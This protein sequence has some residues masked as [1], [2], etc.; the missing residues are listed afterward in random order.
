LTSTSTEAYVSALNA[1]FS[2]IL[3]DLVQDL[4]AVQLPA[5]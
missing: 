2:E 1:A 4:A 5:Q 3:A